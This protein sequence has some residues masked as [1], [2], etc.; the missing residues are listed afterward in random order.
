MEFNQQYH[1]SLCLVFLATLIGFVMSLRVTRLEVPRHTDAHRTATLVCEFN[2]G[3]GKLYSLKW[4]KDE[5]EF[6]RYTPN[7]EPQKQF[8]PQDGLIL[9]LNASDM[10]KVTLDDLTFASSGSYQCEVSTEGP[11]FETSSKSANMTVVVYPTGDPRIEGLA[12]PYKSDEYVTGNCTALPSNPPPIIDW[13]INGNK[14]EDSHMIERY[15]MVKS[16]G[17]LYSYSLGLRMIPQNKLSQRSYEQ[18]GVIEFRCSVTLTGLPPNEKKWDT[19]KKIYSESHKEL[20]NQERL[21]N[22]LGRQFETSSYL[23]IILCWKCLSLI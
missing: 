2:L 23:L 15:P 7:E 18:D 3:G 11:N 14:V 12:S 21:S 10:N 19:L 6:Y 13:Y 5:N 1:A 8:F 4:Y 22:S 9:N 16:E 17:P 20:G